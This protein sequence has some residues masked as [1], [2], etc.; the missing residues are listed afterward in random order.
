MFKQIYLIR[1]ADQYRQKEAVNINENEQITNEKIILSIKGEKQAEEMSKLEE[2][3]HIQE[4]WSSNY[5]RAISTAKYIAYENNID[6][7]IDSNLNE[8]K[9]GNKN[10]LK[11]M[12]NNFKYMYTTEQILNKDLKSSDGEN[13]LEAQSRFKNCFNKIIANN[14]NNKI[15]IVS[16]G[17]IIKF[18]LLTF[19]S[20]NLDEKVFKWNNKIIA[21]EKLNS[22]EIIKL[23]LN[24]NNEIVD[25]F[26]ISY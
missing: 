1:H 6:I 12:S 25:V 22:P 23:I 14:S 4:V 8:R 3:K 11:D 18:F 10:E 21:K 9:L 15:A 5:V 13:S 26:N 24:K 2:L 7:K 16:H 17:A 20:F 19:T